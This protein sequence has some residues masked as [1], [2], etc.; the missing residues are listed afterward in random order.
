MIAAK[1]RAYTPHG[2]IVV[3]GE[4]TRMQGPLHRRKPG[5]KVGEGPS[6][7]AALMSQ[8]G[9]SLL[10][11]LIGSFIV[12]LAAVGTVLMFAAGHALVSSESDNRIA[13]QLAQQRL[14]QVRALGFGGDADCWHPIVNATRIPAACPQTVTE[15][16]I[17]NQ[18][19]YTRRTVIEGVCGGNFS[20]AETVFSC[21][22]S[23]PGVG[24]E[25]KRITVTVSPI[26][27]RLILGYQTSAA[28]QPQAVTLQSMLVVH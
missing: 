5:L 23:L 16:T 12:A 26:Q 20:V 9:L 15:P 1:L 17:Q 13:L 25:A 21:V 10:E 11:V 3:L 28:P 19:G 22:P 2:P 8:A 7:R 6:S 14:E 27:G 18:P 24:V 4:A